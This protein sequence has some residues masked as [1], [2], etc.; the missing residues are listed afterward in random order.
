MKGSWNNGRDIIYHFCWMIEVLS[1]VFQ[2]AQLPQT[3]PMLQILLVQRV[4]QLMIESG[5]VGSRGFR[6][7]SGPENCQFGTIW[8]LSQQSNVHLAFI[9]G[10][11]IAKLPGPLQ[12]FFLV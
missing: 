12:Y 10:V 3:F 2:T 6:Q 9:K 7:R 8:T 11:T 4:A 5:G 1:L